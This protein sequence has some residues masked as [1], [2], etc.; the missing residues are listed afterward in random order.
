MT[1]IYPVLLGT[2]KRFCVKAT[3]PRAWQQISSDATPPRINFNFN[4]Y[5]MA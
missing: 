2:G 4:T 3:P 5:E 1:V